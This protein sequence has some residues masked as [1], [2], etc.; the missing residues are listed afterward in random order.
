MEPSDI[1][2]ASMAHIQAHSSTSSGISQPNSYVTYCQHPPFLDLCS[3]HQL[4]SYILLIKGS[5]KTSAGKSN[6]A[7]PSSVTPDFS[8][9]YMDKRSASYRQM[10]DW[11]SHYQANNQN[12]LVNS[13][14]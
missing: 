2:A 10:P 8:T 3:S 11:F 13:W 6:I 1:K 4:K 12:P 7:N 9:T 5:Q 14:S